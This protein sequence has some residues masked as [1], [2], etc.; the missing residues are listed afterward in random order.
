MPAGAFAQPMH[1]V[2]DRADLVH[3]N[4]NGSGTHELD[5][6]HFAIVLSPRQFQIATGMCYV[7]P[8]TSKYKPNLGA[9]QAP[10]PSLHALSKPTWAL[11]H[12]IRA[13][14]YRARAARTV[15]RLDLS[16]KDH[17]RFLENL[18]VDS[19]FDIIGG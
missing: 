19:L 6:P 17:K 5:G 8:C 12:Q 7:A 2:P 1:A 14:D 13:I 18:V 9:L 11:V 10:L 4:L 16:T 3:L 15:D